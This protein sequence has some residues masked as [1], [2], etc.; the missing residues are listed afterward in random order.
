[1]FYGYV[2]FAEV[3]YL[4]GPIIVFLCRMLDMCFMFA[5]ANNILFN[6]V[7]SHCMFFV[8]A[9][10]PHGTILQFPVRLQGVALTWP[11]HVVH[12][13]HVLCYNLD[14]MDVINAHRGAFV[15]EQLAL[16]HVL[17]KVIIANKQSNSRF[18]YLPTLVPSF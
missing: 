16:L 3:H 2:A 15:H 7:K 10:Y 8:D 1:M 14:D 9:P 13:G 17:T 4:T 11:E 5:D 12:L 6:H 18:F